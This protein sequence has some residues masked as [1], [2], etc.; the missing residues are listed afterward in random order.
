MPVL[1]E[2]QR[3][4]RHSAGSFAKFCSCDFSQHKTPSVGIAGPCLAFANPAL[5]P[6]R[7]RLR[8][9]FL[10]RNSGATG[11]SLSVR[12]QQF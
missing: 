4:S 12:L 5:G 6:C 10:P 2:A 8:G 3:A 7:H 1:D 11:E 9:G